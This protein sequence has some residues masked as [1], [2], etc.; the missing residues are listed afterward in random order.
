MCEGQ[1]TTRQ[2][3]CRQERLIGGGGLA[4]A[5]AGSVLT[6]FQDGSHR[7][8]EDARP[9]GKSRMAGP[10][11]REQRSQAR[12]VCQSGPTSRLLGMHP[13]CTDPESYSPTGAELVEGNLQPSPA[14]PSSAQSSPSMRKRGEC[15]WCNWAFGNFGAFGAP[16][17]ECLVLVAPCAMPPTC[18]WRMLQCCDAASRSLVTFHTY[19]VVVVGLISKY[20]GTWRGR[21][22]RY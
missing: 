21:Y 22:Q 10:G 19:Y 9:T 11:S 2:S 15:A 18:V 17:C 1:C 13:L 7:D 6:K 3:V 4:T 12:L 16:D 8:D 20:L 5:P 14:Q